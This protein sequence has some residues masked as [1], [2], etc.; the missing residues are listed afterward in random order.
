LK[1]LN[2][3]R[4]LYRKVLDAFGQKC[5]N[6]DAEITTALQQGDVELAERLAHTLKGNGGNL[7]AKRLQQAALALESAIKGRQACKEELER[8]SA[9][10]QRVIAAIPAL[11]RRLE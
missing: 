4:G 1:R 8:F 9:E 6:A 11:L 3:N 10:L 7:G 2:G 5:A